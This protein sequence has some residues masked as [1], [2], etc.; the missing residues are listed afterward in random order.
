MKYITTKRSFTAG[1][2]SPLIKLRD[3][4][5]RYPNGCLT[6]LNM[7]ITPQGPATRR[8][9]TIFKFDLTEYCASIGMGDITCVRTVPF[10]FSKTVSYALYFVSDGTIDRIFFV[11]GD[12]VIE[13]TPGS[14]VPYSVLIGAGL[15]FDCENFDYAQQKDYMYI[16]YGASQTLVLVRAGHTSWSIGLCT[17]T[18]V[19][20]DWSAVL[21]WPERVT[22]YNQRLILASNSTEPQS[23]WVSKTADFTDFIPPGTLTS[24]SPFKMVLASGTHNK[25][26][27]ISGSKK[28]FLG[29][30][31][32]EWV[33]TSGSDPFSWDTV[34]AESQ[35]NQ[36]SNPT[37]PIRT[38]SSMLF[39]EHMGRV[40]SKLD[41]DYKTDSFVASDITALAPH[42]FA[43]EEI[44]NWSYQKTPNSII[45]SVT[46]AGNMIGLTMQMQHGVVGWHKHTTQGSVKDLCC[47]PDSDNRQTATWLAV[48][49]TVE[50]SSVE[51]EHIYIEKMANYFMYQTDDTDF[52]FLDSA[53]LYT[54][55]GSTTIDG[56]EH[57]EGQEVGIIADGGSH[58]AQTVVGGE[59]ELQKVYDK[60]WVGLKYDS[61]ITPT[62]PTINMR[63]GSAE[64]RLKRV[65]HTLVALYRSVGFSYGSE[66]SRFI[67]EPFRNVS[68]PTGVGVPPFTGTK[69]VTYPS[70]W[71]RDPIVTIKQTH[72]LPL[73]VL[74]LTDFIEIGETDDD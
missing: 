62:E 50:V 59:I 15:S 20:T 36:G 9:G 37:K 22:F 13:T 35:S 17:L 12:G 61:V 4:I 42:M 54:S 68:D 74:G 46:D 24:A 60:V 3:D 41:Y 31:G 57:L 5:E 23:V 14:G 69:K 18:S 45:W 52:M 29:T 19:P 43:N 8:P 66:G 65:I 58:A 56:L 72:P 71:S 73:T 34:S 44:T 49:R 26:M 30:L 33:I 2:V 32:D 39:V 10:V 21:G 25:I 38:A 47:I 27:W 40:A 28:L 63:D 48:E 7:V 16:A 51:E 11:Y 1:E 70:S 67:E 55:P 6:L 53:K 64:G